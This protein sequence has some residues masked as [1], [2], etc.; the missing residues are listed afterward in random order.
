M[1]AFAPLEHFRGRA[2]RAEHLGRDRLNSPARIPLRAGLGAGGPATGPRGEAAPRRGRGLCGSGCQTESGRMHRAAGAGLFLCAR[3]AR[4]SVKS[5]PTHRRLK[6]NHNQHTAES[7]ILTREKCLSCAKHRLNEGGFTEIHEWEL[8][9]PGKRTGKLAISGDPELPGSCPCPCCSPSEAG[10]AGLGGTRVPGGSVRRHHGPE[11][12]RG[13]ADK[14]GRLPLQLAGFGRPPAPLRARLPP[15]RGGCSRRPPPRYR[16]AARRGR[17]GAPG[18]G[19]PPSEHPPP[20]FFGG[21]RPGTPL[22]E[23]PPAQGTAGPCLAFPVAFAFWRRWHR[24]AART[25]K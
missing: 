17:A 19:A 9:R 5:M 7:W 13:A 4:F 1:A 10:A 6:K 18:W 14:G 22:G 24:R 3:G 16:P 12:A 11:A 21:E 23:T 25:K 15:R 2:E 20:L 8:G